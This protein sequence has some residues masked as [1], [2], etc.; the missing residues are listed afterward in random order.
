MPLI[1]VFYNFIF[2]HVILKIFLPIKL[3]FVDFKIYWLW[4]KLLLGDQLKS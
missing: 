4:N 1:Y 3:I 2:I